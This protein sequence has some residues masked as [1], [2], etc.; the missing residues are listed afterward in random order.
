MTAR[1]L[2]LPCAIAALLCSGL[3]ADPQIRHFD[4]PP[5]VLLGQPVYWI[6]EV[7]HPLWES[8][9]LTLQ[10]PA[11]AQMQVEGSTH[12]RVQ[13]VMITMYRVR[14]IAQSLSLNDPLAAVFTDTSGRQFPVQG[15][16]VRVTPISGDSLDVRDP[17]PPRFRKAVSARSNTAAVT[18]IA[19]L[20][21]FLM[22][23]W[24]MR[25]NAASPQQTLLRNLKEALSLAGGSKPPDPAWLCMLLRSELLWGEPV[26]AV[27]VAELSERGRQT[28]QHA[29]LSEALATLE[30][31][32][33][34]GGVV[35]DAA[36]LE[37]TVNAAME[38]LEKR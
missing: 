30:E 34:S 22:V 5:R 28:M 23:R 27:T 3:Q 36:M 10:P 16:P 37:K 20:F 1:T 19:V 8:Y 17:E 29:I 18:V 14:F 11:G 35:R 4:A 7:R 12:R 38:I 21:C 24:W 25:R 15:R 13:D 9:E 6:L 33:Y 31:A 26:G 2:I 32:R